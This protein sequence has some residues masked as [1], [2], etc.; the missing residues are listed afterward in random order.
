MPGMPLSLY[1]LRALAG[2]F[3]RCRF[4]LRVEGSG[5]LPPGAYVVAANH[6]SLY[7]P[8]LLGVTLPRVPRFLVAD[9]LLGRGRRWQVPWMLR[10]LLRSILKLA[11]AIP[12]TRVGR[13]D[14]AVRWALRVLRGGDSLG[15]FV[16]GGVA[17]KATGPLPG[18]A[19]LAQRAGCP[20]VPCHIDGLPAPGHLRP[21]VTVRFGATLYAAEQE[22]REA[23]A[24]RIWSAILDLGPHS[25]G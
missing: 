10:G 15:V 7:D 2:L 20:V 16:Q 13:D 19:W 6:S 21:K 4:E 12:V 18:A 5:D 23:F 25:D 22:Y 17:G 24:R 8:V 14:R 1:L 11:G 9:E 3:V